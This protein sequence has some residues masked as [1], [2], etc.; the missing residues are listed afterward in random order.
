M[1]LRERV[2]VLVTVKASPDP[3]KAYRGT[4]CVAGVRLDD[5]GSGAWVRIYPVEFRH[6]DSELQFEKFELIEED[7]TRSW[8]DARSESFRPNWETMIR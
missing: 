4:V 5:D 1:V 2:C 6:L 8:T 3:S 7:L